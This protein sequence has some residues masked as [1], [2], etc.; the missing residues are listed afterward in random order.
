MKLIADIHTHSISSGDAFSTIS[1]NAAAAAA[2]GLKFLA[3]TDHAPG[4][5]G[6]PLPHYFLNLRT[7]PRML[8]GV[9]LLSG[10]EIDLLDYDGALD[11][12]QSTL[13]KLD[14]VVASMHVDVIAPATKKDHTRGW[15]AVA[16]NPDIDVIGHCGDPRF[17]FDHEEVVKAFAR[18]DKIV[19]I[20]TA[21]VHTRP[22][23]EENC[24]NIVRLCMKHGVRLVV[25]SDAHHSC[26]IGDFGWGLEM[27]K[28]LNVPKEL[29][30]CAD[31]NQFLSY[32][33][34]KMRPES[35]AVL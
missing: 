18:A 16:E 34:E 29:V 4:K 31:Y 19:E 25:N 9:F 27:L 20:N 11:L 5:P 15:L 8:G 35:P 17:D 30:L 21:S 2:R 12:P 32:V 24:E 6:A 10:A 28:R 13:A 3:T 23:S 22:G 7:L 26:R 33:K 1:E 14:I